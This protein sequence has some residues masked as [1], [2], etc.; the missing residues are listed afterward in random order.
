M[1]KIPVVVLLLRPLSVSYTC[2]GAGGDQAGGY[3]GWRGPCCPDCPYPSSAA[4]SGS[5]PRGNPDPLCLTH[6]HPP[7]GFSSLL[8]DLPPSNN[9]Y[10]YQQQQQPPQPQPPPPQSQPQAPAQGTSAVGGAPPLHTPSPDGCTPPGG[11]PTGSEGYG[12][13][14]VMAMHPPPLQHGGYHAHQ[15]HPHSHPAQQ[16][17]PQQQAQGQAPINSTG[18]GE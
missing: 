17:P 2:P 5:Q 10:V 7:A 8:G 11:K 3:Q 18:F 4:F 15:H 13:P 1:A 6:P 9:Y 14:P 12:P 16:P